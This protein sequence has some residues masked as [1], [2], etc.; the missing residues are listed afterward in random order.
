M[1]LLKELNKLVEE[2]KNG[3]YLL[4][5]EEDYLVDLFL[6]KV[7]SRYEDIN[8]SIFNEKTSVQDVIGACDTMPLFEQSRL[9]IVKES[10]D[11]EPRLADYLERISPFTCLIYVKRD[12]DRR[13]Y[14]YKAAKKHGTVYEFNKLKFYELE[15]WLVD[16]AREKGIKLEERAASYISQMALNLRDGVNCINALISY[17][18]PGREISLQDVKDFYGKFV[19]DNIFNFIDEVQ[20]GN[21]KAIENLN[22][23]MTQ[24]VSPL[25]ILSMLEWQY[26]LLIKARVLLSQGISDI[27]EKLGV[28]RYTA[29]K[30]VNIARK[31]KEDHFVQNMRTCLQ[32]EM[33]IKTGNMK[34]ELAIEMLA[35]KLLSRQK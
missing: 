21:G 2:V 17:V 7:R 9:V 22:D 33:D 4:T 3:F 32:T 6:Q 8:I 13:T 29:E 34:E 5:G 12:V 16:Y 14:F 25:Y 19:D 1:M 28:H 10:V 23:L 26:R 11:D 24:G 31:Y 27:Y 15:R 20:Q 30:A 35:V 18:Y